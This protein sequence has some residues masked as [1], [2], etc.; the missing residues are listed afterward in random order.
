MKGKISIIIPIYNGEEYIERC[1]ESILKQSYKDI[2]IILVNDGSIDKTEKVCKELEKRDKRIKYIYQINNGVSC[3]RNNGILNATG[4]YIAFIDGDDWVDEK[5]CEI[6]LKGMTKDVQLSVVGIKQTKVYNSENSI[7]EKETNKITQDEAFKLIFI[8]S[9]FF[10]Y[11]VNKLYR[12]TLIDELGD[13]PFDESIHA[14]EDTLF[15]AKYIT[16]CKKISY[17]KSQLYLYFQHQNSVTKTK[18]FNIKR[19][20]VFDS[21]EKIEDIYIKN[22]SNN[23][24]YLY[25]FYMYNYY[26][27]YLLI[28]NSKSNYKLNKSKVNEIYKYI[29]QSNQIT[30]SKKIKIFIKFRFPNLNNFIFKIRKSLKKEG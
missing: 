30:V 11:P 28:H 22:S 24:I 29:I 13:K 3:A 8:D 7:I 27:I 16:K 6:L 10:G 12:K 21:L 1:V 25:I 26:L 18:K 5:Y 23:L 9:N 15:N 2:E 17:N 20:T 4:E 19:V 14:C